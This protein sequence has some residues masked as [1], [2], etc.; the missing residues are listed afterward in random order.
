MNG[1]AF[2]DS[3]QRLAQGSGEADWRSAAGRA[4]YALM[5]EGRDA[6]ARRGFVLPRRDQVHAFVRLRFYTPAHPDLRAIGRA[7]E[8]LGHLR[9]Q[10]DYELTVAGPFANATRAQNAVQQ[11]RTAIAVLDAID[12]DPSRRAAAVAAIR[13]AFSP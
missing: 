5:L 11:A 9:N 3:A 7:L 1:R 12:H 8:D 6:L 10:G 4:Y 13:A 2:L